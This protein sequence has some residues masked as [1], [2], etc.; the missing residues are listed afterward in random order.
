MWF[1]LLRLI[2]FVDLHKLVNYMY[3]LKKSHDVSRPK[4]NE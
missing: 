4:L 2:S 1:N 3:V